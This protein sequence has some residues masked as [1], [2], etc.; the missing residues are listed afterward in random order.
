MTTYQVDFK[1]WSD[2]SMSILKDLHD[3]VRSGK[4]EIKGAI[5]VSPTALKIVTVKVK[6]VKK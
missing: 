1:S 3:A 2:F 4:E 6:K 5:A